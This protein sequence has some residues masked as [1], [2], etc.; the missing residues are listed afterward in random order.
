MT[1]PLPPKPVNV[2]AEP[3]LTRMSNELTSLRASVKK[4]A[5]AQNALFFNVKALS[6]QVQSCQARSSGWRAR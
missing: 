6:D 1:A 4:L 3:P 5:R 2:P